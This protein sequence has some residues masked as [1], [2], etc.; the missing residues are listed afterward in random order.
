LPDFL[1]PFKHYTAG[2][3]EG[4]LHHMAD[5]SLS[6]LYTNADE[7]T[8][9]R[10]WKEFSGKLQQ[11]AGIIESGAQQLYRQSYRFFTLPIHPLKRLEEAL[12]RLPPLPLQ[13]TVMVKTLWWLNPTHPLCLP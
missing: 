10:W 6:D 12:S 5:G 3:I 2:E 11:W 1:L 4:V 9:R 7:R 8:L 13:W